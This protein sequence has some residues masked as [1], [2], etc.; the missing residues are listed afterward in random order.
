MKT[1]ARVLS[2][3]DHPGDNTVIEIADANEWW[4]PVWT[5]EATTWLTV[6]VT[7]DTGPAAIGDHWNGATFE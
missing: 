6:E 4:E 2:K 5:I 3:P 1:F 7:E